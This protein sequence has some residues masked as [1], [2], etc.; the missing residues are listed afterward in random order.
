MQLINTLPMSPPWFDVDR[1]D[2]QVMTLVDSG[3]SSN[4]IGY[5]F[6]IPQDQVLQVLWLHWEPGY[7]RKA[8]KHMMICASEQGYAQVA[9][10]VDTESTAARDKMEE[11]LR[12]QFRAN[13]SN[14]KDHVW[15]VTECI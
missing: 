3:T 15:L 11:L 12:G 5:A 8:I 10:L 14:R 9:V 13:A 4:L 1:D 7:A 6:L 2:T